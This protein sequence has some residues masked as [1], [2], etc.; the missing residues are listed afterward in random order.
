MGLTA[1]ASWVGVTI[2]P[3]QAFENDFS[4]NHLLISAI[5]LGLLLVAIG[6]LS[7]QYDFKKHFAFTYLLL[8]GNLAAVA[9]LAG[10]FIFD[11]K[12]IYFLIVI[13]L[14]Y[15]SVRY[16]QSHQSYLFLLLGVIYGYIAITYGIFHTLPDDAAFTLATVYFLA[17]GIGVVISLIK[18]KD[19]LAWER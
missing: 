6:W 19:I 17:S 18:I 13:L 7:E 11:W 8:G 3:Q 1:L 16:A 4:N 9:A 10:L 15:L 14:S 5:V 12:I 2:A